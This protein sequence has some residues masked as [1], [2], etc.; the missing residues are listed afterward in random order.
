MRRLVASLSALFVALS[1]AATSAAN[2]PPGPDAGT[3]GTSGT[4]GGT[5]GTGGGGP[6]PNRVP[7]S[8][9]MKLYRYGLSTSPTCTNLTIYDVENPSFVDFTK[10]PE[11]GSASVPKGTYPCVAFEFDQVVSATPATTLGTCVAG[12]EATTD[13]CAEFAKSAAQP[14]PTPAEPGSFDGIQPLGGGE[15]WRTCK[16]GGDHLVV[17]LTTQ[18][19]PDMRSNAGRPPQDA[20]DTHHGYPLGAP[21]IVGEH[22]TGTL[23]VTSNAEAGSD[24]CLA[25]S[26]TFS[27]ESAN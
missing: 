1:F 18:I 19:T 11:L 24:R 15:P 2:D 3:S 17:Y 21:L 4:S 25:G 14:A 5:S 20:S 22:T 6:A 10:N 27:F 16:P 8:L 7:A 12:Q 23:I 26:P 9:S 13:L